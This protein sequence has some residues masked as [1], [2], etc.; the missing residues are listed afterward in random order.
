MDVS[1]V[2]RI[3]GFKF[4]NEGWKIFPNPHVGG[5]ITLRFSDKNI[6]TDNMVLQVIDG[7]GKV[8]WHINQKS[9]FEKKRIEDAL[10]K[11]PPGIYIIR[12]IHQNGTE[13]VKWL[14]K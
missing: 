11:L 2:F 3:N 7:K 14:Q 13:Q 4:R 12:L 5:N 6:G 9:N 10:K 1:P 8:Y